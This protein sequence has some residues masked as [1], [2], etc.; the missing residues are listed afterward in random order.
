[1][2]R[3]LFLTVMTWSTVSLISVVALAIVFSGEE[4]R[5]LV[6]T[7]PTSPQTAGRRPTVKRR[8]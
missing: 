2:L 5:V 7:R 8:P 1:M 4:R 3:L 6:R